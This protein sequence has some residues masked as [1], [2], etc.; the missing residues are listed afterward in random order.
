VLDP[1][2]LPIV[3]FLLRTQKHTGLG[4]I[5]GSKIDLAQW[6]DQTFRQTRGVRAS[7]SIRE[8]LMFQGNTPSGSAFWDLIPLESQ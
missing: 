5:S 7:L 2:K 6:F 1:S 8:T 4:E 3:K